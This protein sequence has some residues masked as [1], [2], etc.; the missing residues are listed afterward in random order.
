MISTKMQEAINKQVQAEFASAYLY[1]SMSAYCEAQNLKGFA[2][3]LKTQ[4][5]EETAH[6]LKLI[7]FLAERGGK[8]VLQAIETP[9]AEFGTP[10]QVFEKVLAH[11]QH[12]TSLINSLYE[13]ALNEKDYASQIFLQWF[14]N[15]QVEEEASA[16]EVLEKLKMIPEKSGAI[17]YIDKELGKRG[18]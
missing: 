15:E 16:T 7:D 17:F 13:I 5:Q 10:V 12:V 11:E 4:Y 9:Q 14:I 2:Y 3:W 1:L 8:V 6:A 18:A